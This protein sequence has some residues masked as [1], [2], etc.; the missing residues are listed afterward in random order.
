[1][2]KN[3]SSVASAAV[4]ASQI[5][6]SVPRPDLQRVIDRHAFTIN[7]A[8]YTCRTTCQS[9]LGA[10]IAWYIGHAH[11]LVIG[12]ALEVHRDRSLPMVDAT[13]EGDVDAKDQDSQ[14]GESTWSRADGAGL[15]LVKKYLAGLTSDLSGSL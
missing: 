9:A 10:L 6:A 3:T 2:R 4:P 1:M 7:A 13:V 14:G 8:A 11:R 5:P 12:R 15:S